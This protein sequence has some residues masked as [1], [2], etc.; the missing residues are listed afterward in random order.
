M[1][2]SRTQIITLDKVKTHANINGNEQAYTLAKLGCELDHIDAAMPH[3]H[4]HPT[5]Y[6]LQKDLWHSMQE[7][8]DKGLI[9]HLGKHVLKYDKTII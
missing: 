9:R 3:G 1:L 8:L 2:Q 7:T 5:P 6:Y 4:A